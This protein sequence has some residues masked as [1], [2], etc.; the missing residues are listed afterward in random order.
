MIQPE[1]V[2]LGVNEIVE[3][4]ELRGFDVH[5]LVDFHEFVGIVE[6]LVVEDQP[7]FQGEVVG[8][9]EQGGLEDGDDVEEGDTVVVEGE[10][11]A[12]DVGEQGDELVSQVA[13]ALLQHLVV[14]ELQPCSVQI[15]ELVGGFL[16][17]LGSLRKRSQFP[18]VLQLEGVEVEH[19]GVI[20]FEVRGFHKRERGGG[21][22]EEDLLGEGERG[23]EQRGVLLEIR[24]GDGGV[25]G[26]S[27]GE[28]VEDGVQR[29]FDAV[30]IV[31]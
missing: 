21:G 19:Q 20:S 18:K 15:Q 29:R 24:Q 6:A 14:L 26:E 28:E 12:E 11:L 23:G 9:A 5:G 10:V 3:D 30:L 13:L 8:G 16:E 1:P 31:I 17:F 22:Q 2:H 27:P 25:V 7:G 4:L